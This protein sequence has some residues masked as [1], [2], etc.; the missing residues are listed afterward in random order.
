MDR[1]FD[2]S[3][4]ATPPDA[5]GS[6]STGYP[7]SGNPQT[8]TPATKPGPWWYYQVTEEIR[9]VIAAAGITPDHTDVTQLVAAIKRLISGGDFKDSVRVASTANIAALTGLLTIDGVVLTAG[10]RVLVKD[11]G[12]GAD[13]G[14]YIAAAGAWTRATD[15]DTGSELSPG[16]TIPVEEGTVNADTLWNLTNDGAVTI[17][18]T[19]LV[20]AKR[21]ISDASTTLK[22]K[23]Q[24]A[25][26]VEAQAFADALKAITPAT[27]AGGFQGGNQSMAASGYQKLPGGLILQWGSS[28]G[29][30]GGSVA[31]TF[32]IAFPNAC[33]RVVATSQAGNNTF[34]P[35]GVGAPSL[36]GVTLYLNTT[37]ADGTG[38]AYFAIG[39]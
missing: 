25:T 31:V 1:V 27:L 39:R 11:Q 38:I 2:S 19:A 20:F 12:T 36:T 22:G 29:T 33:Y 30:S 34:N 26:S 16:A 14:I 9:N 3:A 15:A 28:T 17:G 6:P 23:V 7:S 37:G 8:A 32:P 10:D 21:D 18:T 35:S 24:L 13:N 5:P 4:A